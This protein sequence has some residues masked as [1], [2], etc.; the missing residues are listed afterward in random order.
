[1]FADDRIS[2]PIVDGPPNSCHLRPIFAIRI[3]TT[4]GDYRGAHTCAIS[5]AKSNLCSAILMS[6]DLS[7]VEESKV[8]GT[9][10]APTEQ[11]ADC[12]R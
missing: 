10:M 9:C 6:Y 5:G 11:T 2:G 4:A 1:M 12:H 7:D 3:M 8:C